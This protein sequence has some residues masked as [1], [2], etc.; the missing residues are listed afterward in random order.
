[1]AISCFPVILE[2]DTIAF[3][4]TDLFHNYAN[5]RDAPFESKVVLQELNRDP[6]IVDAI[7][8]SCHQKDICSFNHLHDIP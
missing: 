2:H 1:M 7:V 4:S 8:E 3:S 5:T 6:P